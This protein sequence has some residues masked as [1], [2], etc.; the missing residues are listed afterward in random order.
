M[1]VQ[2]RRWSTNRSE[3]SYEANIDFEIRFIADTKVLGCT[4]IELPTGTYK[5]RNKSG[6]LDAPATT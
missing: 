5:L 6:R 1:W 4:W 2:F 3:R